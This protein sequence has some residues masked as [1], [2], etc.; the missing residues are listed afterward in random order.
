MSVAGASTAVLDGKIR[1]GGMGTAMPS[2]ANLLSDE[3]IE[4]LVAYL[5]SLPF[6]V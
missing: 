1:R 3:E 4:A 2:Y 6:P 5:W